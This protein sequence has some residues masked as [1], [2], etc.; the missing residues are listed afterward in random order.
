MI[1]FKIKGDTMSDF[2]ADELMKHD[3]SPNG[4]RVI[5]MSEV[6]KQ[7]EERFKHQVNLN[8]EAAKWDNIMKIMVPLAI[9]FI[10][11]IIV[12]TFLNW[13][14]LMSGI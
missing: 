9:I 6:Q 7:Q 14:Y 5:R 11:I 2:D 8:K 12:V 3:V 10:I 4:Q 13:D 1:K